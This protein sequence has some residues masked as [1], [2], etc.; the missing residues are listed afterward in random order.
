[1]REKMLR[2]KKTPSDAELEAERD[3]K[4]AKEVEEWISRAE[5]E[6]GEYEWD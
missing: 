3:R 2:C 4:H 1:M 5:G 6:E